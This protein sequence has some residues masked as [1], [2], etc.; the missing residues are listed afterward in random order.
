MADVFTQKS[1]IDA[2]SQEIIVS[3]FQNELI[4]KAML[5]PTVSDYSM[6]AEQGS[7]KVKVPRAGSFT[8]EVKSGGSPYNAQALTAVTDDIDLDKEEG[9][10]VAVENI[11]KLQSKPELMAEYVKRMASAMAKKVDQRIYD[12][13]KLASAAAPDHKIDWANAPTDTMTKADFI[14]ALKLIKEANVD[15]QDGQLFALINP[16]RESEILALSDFVDADKWFAGSQ[17]AKLNGMIGRAYGFNILCSTIVS[18]DEVV[19][20]HKSHVGVAFQQRPVVTSQYDIRY[21][22]DML[23]LKQVAGYKVLQ[24][25]KAGV[26]IG[27]P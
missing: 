18:D 1:N 12:Q 9:V 25:G 21:D 5:L 8:A 10:L 11:A 17:D 14:A 24:A 2:V 13:L 22:S 27:T 20:Y 15:I 6:F 3:M 23:L 26:L 16:K 7:D 19:L 4:A